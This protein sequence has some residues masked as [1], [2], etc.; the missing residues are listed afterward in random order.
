MHWRKPSIS[1]VVRSTRQADVQKCTHFVC[2]CSK[3]SSSHSET[4]ATTRR[5]RELFRFI[6]TK[7]KIQ[8]RTVHS[9]FEKFLRKDTSSVEWNN[10]VR[11]WSTLEYY[12]FVETHVKKENIV[13]VKF[14]WKDSNYNQDVIWIF[15]LFFHRLVIV[16]CTVFNIIQYGN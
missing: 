5:I 11:E 9:S 15:L 2:G 13:S 10:S 14:L 16:A 3:A 6:I 1:T 8:I 4:L 12:I 7:K